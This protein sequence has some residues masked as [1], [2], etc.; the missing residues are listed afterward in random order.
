MHGIDGKMW[1]WE[2]FHPLSWPAIKPDRLA[3]VRR[4]QAAGFDF[5]DAFRSGFTG[6]RQNRSGAAKRRAPFDL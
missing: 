4:F 5:C 3:S 2:T 1:F 6:K